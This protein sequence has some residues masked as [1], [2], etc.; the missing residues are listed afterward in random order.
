[1]MGMMMGAGGGGSVRMS[2][3]ERAVQKNKEMAKEAE[4]AVEDF[5]AAV[6]DEDKK[7]MSSMISK[8][9]RGILRRLRNG[10]LGDKDFDRLVKMYQDGKVGES[11]KGRR[12]SERTV[13]VELPDR[14]RRV[15]V[16]QE[17]NNWLIS[18][19][20]GLR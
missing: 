1:M 12:R 19:L 8:R 10:E 5:L 2:P 20:D 16:K 15:K 7:K 18:S 3:K 14:R 11:R 13:S 9:S 4:Q 17:S 6:N